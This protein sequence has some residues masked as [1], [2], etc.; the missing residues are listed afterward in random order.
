M[1]AKTIRITV[2]TMSEHVEARCILAGCIM[3]TSSPVSIGLDKAR[4]TALRKMKSM[5]EAAFAYDG[6]S[7]PVEIA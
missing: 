3:K 5:L 1:N 2:R 7:L 6:V 4:F